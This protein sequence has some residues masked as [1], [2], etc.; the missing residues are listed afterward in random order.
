MTERTRESSPNLT[1][2]LAGLFYLLGAGGA[3]NIFY[4]GRRLAASTDAATTANAILSSEPIYRLAVAGGFIG[5]ATYIVVA[6]LLYE[7]FK[8]VN[9]SLSLLAM[10]FALMGVAVSVIGGL[11]QLAPL[12]V[13]GGA[14]YLNVLGPDQLQALALLFLKFYAHGFTISMMFFGVYM[15][16]IGGLVIGSTFMPRIIGLLTVAAGLSYLSHSVAFVL[17]PPLA[18]RLASYVFL[19]GVG[20][21]ALV[22]WLLLVGVNAKKWREQAGHKECC[23]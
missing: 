6:L 20:E 3:F 12:I 16:L 21:G 8:P 15:I 2:R 13:L 9:R 1:A 17:S 5:G 11:F 18:A 7:L 10:L 14:P 22:L 23:R 4:V 19:F